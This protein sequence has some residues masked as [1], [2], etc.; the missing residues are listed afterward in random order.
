MNARQRMKYLKMG[1]ECGHR[2]YS[3]FMVTDDPYPMYD[4]EDE[5]KLGKFY[6]RHGSSNDCLNCKHYTLS[7]KAMKDAREW[8]KEHKRFIKECEKL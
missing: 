3:R 2:N 8:D 4:V 7:K 5:C 1:A 6:V